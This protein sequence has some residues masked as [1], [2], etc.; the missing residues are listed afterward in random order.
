MDL[1]ASV[2]LLWHKLHCHSNL[3]LLN[4]KWRIQKGHFVTMTWRWHGRRIPKSPTLF[5]I[6]ISE[7]YLTF[8]VFQGSCTP[9]NL[10]CAQ[11]H[12][13]PKYVWPQTNVGIKCTWSQYRLTAKS[14]W[15]Q[16][17][18]RW[19][20]SILCPCTFDPKV[21]LLR[22]LSGMLRSIFSKMNFI[23]SISCLSCCLNRGAQT[24]PV[25]LGNSKALPWS[26]A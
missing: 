8:N 22:K 10:Y 15:P 7:H 23:L 18:Q 17:N 12:L 16:T 3:L 20:Q 2:G 14:V 26:S 13:T 21:G 24:P 11:V 25:L 6:I 4:L 5:L 1:Y 9:G 19:G